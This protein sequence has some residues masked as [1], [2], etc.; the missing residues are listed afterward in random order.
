[1]LAGTLIRDVDDAGRRAVAVLCD[2]DLLVRLLDGLV[3]EH[4]SR[5]MQ[6]SDRMR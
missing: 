1:M 2:D 3:T 6:K 4:Q 5:R